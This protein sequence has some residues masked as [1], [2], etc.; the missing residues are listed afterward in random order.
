MLQNGQKPQHKSTHHENHVSQITKSIQSQ[1]NYGNTH[2]NHNNQ[3]HNQSNHVN[4]ETNHSPVNRVTGGHTSPII[5]T[6]GGNNHQKN[7]RNTQHHSNSQNQEWR[8]PPEETNNKSPEE[9]FYEC[10][11]VVNDGKHSLLQYAMLNFR[12]ST[13]K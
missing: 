1:S 2:V 6:N 11:Q 5:Q 13:E 4:R 8:Q 10:G 7:Q 9:G 3:S 12:Q